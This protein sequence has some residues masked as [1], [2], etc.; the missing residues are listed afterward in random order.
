[1]IKVYG[2]HDIGFIL[3]PSIGKKTDFMLVSEL[4]NLYSNIFTFIMIGANLLT[5]ILLIM[6]SFKSSA[7][8]KAYIY[9]GI[10]CLFFTVYS[11]EYSYRLYTGSLPVYIWIRKFMLC[12]YIY[13][14]FF[15][16]KGLLLYLYNKVLPK[17][18]LP[19]IITGI[20]PILIAGDF[21]TLNSTLKI[22]NLI[23]IVICLILII[24]F[25][26][27]PKNKMLFPISFFT[28]SVL[29]SIIVFTFNLYEITFS[30]IGITV[31][32]IGIMYSLI[33]EFKAIKKRNITLNQKLII[34]PMTGANNRKFLDTLHIQTGD[35]I[36]FFD[37]DYFK[38]FNDTFGHQ[39][40]DA[41]LIDF[42]KKAKELIRKE[43]S[44]SR[45]GGDEFFITFKSSTE[46][47]CTKTALLLKEYIKQKYELVDLSYGISCFQGSV[48]A[49]I[50]F[51]DK[52]MY[53]MKKGR[54]R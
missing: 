20:I 41:L 3:A 45:Y 52:N 34:D 18:S 14:V 1:V 46:S 16:I 30:L 48:P 37:F 27:Y 29:H 47:T 24:L 9:F 2:L 4:Q 33:T 40:G 11:F 15:I 21:I 36:L 44:V 22:Y 26:K 38:K 23:I 50:K 19:L 51:A 54:A 42:V 5:G 13:S 7:Y 32:M 39:K 31:L 43:D 12:S 25:Y 28:A 17:I 35:F 6:M 53:C 8:R 49:T 10:A